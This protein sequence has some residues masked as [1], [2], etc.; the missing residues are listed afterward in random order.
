MMGRLFGALSRNKLWRFGMVY[1]FLAAV[2]VLVVLSACAGELDAGAGVS[3][4]WT[5]QATT[6]SQQFPL[7]LELTQN[8]VSVTGDFTMQL[9]ATNEVLPLSV[10]GTAA[11]EIIS[12]SGQDT[13]GT[14][15]LEGSVSGNTMQGLFVLTPFDGDPTSFDFSV[16][17]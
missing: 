15:Q 9:P 16:A 6:P 17:R 10:T 5:G 2:S 4:T 12:L 11:N 3:G 7:T 14:M 1:R 13:D 8:G